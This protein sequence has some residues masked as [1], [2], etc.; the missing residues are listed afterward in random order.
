M[1][2]TRS[3]PPLHILLVD[4]RVQE[5]P[6][7][8][9]ALSQNYRV[10]AVSNGEE[11]VRVIKRDPPGLIIID[12]GEH[13]MDYLSLFDEYDQQI[14]L[15]LVGN[16]LD[17]EYAEGGFKQSALKSWIEHTISSRQI[18]KKVANLASEKAHFQTFGDFV[19]CSSELIDI[20]RML[21]RVIETDV[22]ILVTGESGTGKELIA[23][24]IHEFSGRKAHPFVAIN[25]AAIPEHLL[26]TELF[27][28]EKGAFTGAATTKVGKLEYA[29]RGTVFL[30]EIGDMP[31]LTQAKIL[32]ALQERTFERVGGHQPVFFRARIVAATNKHLKEEVQRH[33][34]RADLLYRLNAVHVHLPP[35]RERREDI[36]LLI[37]RFV[38]IFNQRY[39]KQLLGVS[40]WVATTLYKYDWPGNIRELINNIQHAVL[41]ADSSRIEMKDLPVQFQHGMK[42]TILLDKLGT[43]PLG[44]LIKQAQADLERQIIQSALEKFDYSKLRCA[45]YLG[46]DRK[47]LYRKMKTL[48]IQD[49]EDEEP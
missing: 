48:D 44:E 6:A 11:G 20:F 10:T 14:P 8:A 18:H 24:G 45:F 16:H 34:F 32:R 22:S 30:D 28:Y 23:R 13:N 26:E 5:R 1:K 15:T 49:R 25:C 27:G 39:N 17:D 47:T 42:A 35:L 37:D 41:L 43:L 29:D 9:L 3:E 33:T 2:A 21:R 40:P 19:T 46:I 38:K 4:Y 7:L 31:L 12:A 36:P